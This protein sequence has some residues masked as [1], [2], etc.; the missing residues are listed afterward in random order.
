MME[1]YSEREANEEED[2][3]G[4]W[5]YSLQEVDQAKEDTDCVTSFRLIWL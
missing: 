2:P 4:S 1:P 5:P 3:G